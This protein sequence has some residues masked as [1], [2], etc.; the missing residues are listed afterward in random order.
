MISFAYPAL[1]WLILL[2]L[3]VYYIFPR[4]GKMY[5]DALQIP[6]VSDIAQVKAQTKGKI[7]VAVARGIA[8]KSGCFLLLLIWALSVAALCRPQ[9][10]GE[11]HKIHQQSRDIVLVVDISKSMLEQDFAYQG[12]YYDRLTAVKNVV[13]H[14][15]EER[16]DDRLALVV[17]GTRAYVQ[18]P[19]TYDRASLQETLF[20][21][22]AGMAGNSTS[23]G[24]AVGLALKHLAGD[25]TQT[26]NKVIV[27]L[28]DGENNDGSISF[29]QAIKL[30][31]EEKVKFYTIGVVS[32]TESFFGGL[33]SLPKNSDLD[34]ASLKQLAAVTKGNYYRAKDV[35]SLFQIYDDINRLEAQ[36]KEGSFVQE[37][38]D[39]FYYPA[40]LAALLFLMLFGIVRRK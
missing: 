22:D 18:V 9:W 23:I 27:L 7:G 14:F 31:A 6:F 32:D 33:F 20:N 24:D 5:G 8:A 25:E 1:G 2:P 36:D 19:L 15:A 11:P 3:A 35:G 12:R 37:T 30:A 17:F 13:S 21:I 16:V 34:E 4:A 10:V 38:K 39:L 40:A 29:P 26:E 28:T